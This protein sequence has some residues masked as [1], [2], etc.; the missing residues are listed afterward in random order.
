MA[1]PD[2]ATPAPDQATSAPERSSRLEPA[3]LLAASLASAVAALITHELWRGGEIVSAALTPLIVAFASEAIR[4][5]ARR[6]SE[7]A[8]ARRPSLAVPGPLA[9]ARRAE[10]DSAAVGPPDPVRERLDESPAAAPGPGRYVEPPEPPP[11]ER[12]PEP[13]GEDLVRADR[14]A[15]P[16]GH[17]RPAPGL[18]PPAGAPT[19]TDR[20]PVAPL[21]VYR[22]RRF[23]VRMAVLTGLLAFLIGAVILTVPEIVGGGAVGGK[24]RTTLFSSSDR[25]RDGGS[26]DRDD[27]RDGGERDDGSQ[28]GEDGGTEPSTPDS[29]SQPNRTPQQ[30]T[31]APGGGESSPPTAPKAPAPP[32]VP[33]AP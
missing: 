10:R 17:R 20:E 11:A 15:P 8:T 33:G 6:I 32:S 12:A 27:N 26:A 19:G 21:R 18:E 25:D 22:R 29:Q 5:P 24:G 14:L 16:D 31:P 3:T 30:T 13:P 7:V 4:R 9:T 23:D 1:A 2:R 28:G